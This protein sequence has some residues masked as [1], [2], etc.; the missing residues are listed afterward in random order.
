MQAGRIR[1]G[2]QMGTGGQKARG[3]RRALPLPFS[4]I[5]GAVGGTREACG[6]VPPRV[7]SDLSTAGMR[8]QSLVAWRCRKGEVAVHP[9]RESAVHGPS[10]PAAAIHQCGCVGVLR[11]TAVR[12]LS[13]GTGCEERVRRIAQDDSR[14]VTLSARAYCV[15]T[16]SA[17]ARAQNARPCF[18]V[19]RVCRARRASRMRD[20]A[21][22]VARC[23]PAAREC[24]G[25]VARQPRF[26]SGTTGRCSTPV[27]Q[28]SGRI[29][30][31]SAACSSTCAAQP[32]MR[33]HTKI[34]V[35]SG[36]SKPIR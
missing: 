27:Y 7:A 9:S 10:F 36:M 12:T 35:K 28:D 14:A 25:N 21:F 16:E 24:G 34:G 20:E 22:L 19:M 31:L 8:R 18:V 1:G 26:A 23:V 5:R 15:S 32:V 30:R 11:C 29:R 3:S 13:C 6:A 33:E 4:E 17:R 2:Q